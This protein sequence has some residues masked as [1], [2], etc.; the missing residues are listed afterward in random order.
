MGF[1]F[2]LQDCG[3]K[4]SLLSPIDDLLSDQFLEVR[5]EKLPFDEMNI[6]LLLS[7]SILGDSVT[8]K[9]GFSI[10]LISM[11]ASCY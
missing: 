10:N 7:Y 1:V 4:S 8:L 3:I 9:T 6:P 5:E 11:L 2:A